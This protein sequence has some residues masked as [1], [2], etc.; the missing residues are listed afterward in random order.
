MVMVVKLSCARKRFFFSFVSC[1]VRP[2]LAAS[3]CRL[4]FALRTGLG[5]GGD[6]ITIC[7]ADDVAITRSTAI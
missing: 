4:G 3:V 6:G 2:S 5:G 7:A 1:I